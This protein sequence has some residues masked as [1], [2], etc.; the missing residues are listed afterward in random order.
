MKDIWHSIQ[1]ITTTIGGWL[2]YYLG[3]VDGL[4]LA[5]L[6]FVV[7]DYITGVMCA[8]VNRRLSSAIGYKGIFKKVSIFILVGVASVLD[9]H[10]LGNGSVIRAAIIFFYLSNEGISL[11]ENAAHL[12]LPIPEKLVRVLH[13]IKEREENKHE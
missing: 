6:L 4:L 13:Q 5:L 2:G 1:A 8:I 3:G 12:G 7:V 11:L 10:I 9:K